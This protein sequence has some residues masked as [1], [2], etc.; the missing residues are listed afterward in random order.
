VDREARGGEC[1]RML[2]ADSSRPEDHTARPP[3]VPSALFCQYIR[4]Q[5]SSRASGRARASAYRTL[6]VARTT[7]LAGASRG[8]GRL[9]SAS[10]LVRCAL[11]NGNWTR[12]CISG[13]TITMVLGEIATI[14][15]SRVSSRFSTLVRHP[16]LIIIRVPF[17]VIMMGG[18]WSVLF[19][20]I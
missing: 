4:D 5:T 1:V 3:C 7:F 12:V 15:T 19:R 10:L 20:L 14:D 11:T 8:D 16:S 17:N 2:S 6:R 9:V 13:R 18:R